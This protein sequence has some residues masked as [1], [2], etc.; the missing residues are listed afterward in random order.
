M[1]IEDARLLCAIR[2]RYFWGNFVKPGVVGGLSSAEYFALPAI[3]KSGLDLFERS[4]LHYWSENLD[5]MHD[6]SEGT[7]ATS[8]GSAIHCAILEP[9]RFAEEYRA[10]PVPEDFPG[11]L[12]SA[13][14]Y[15]SAA[16]SLDLPVT[17]TK[18]VLKQRI[19]E[20]GSTHRFFD[21]IENEFSAFRLLSAADLHAIGR[22]AAGVRHSE[23]ARILFGL[24]R[25]ELTFV[26]QDPETNVWC[27]CRVDRITDDLDILTDI[28]STRDASPSGFARSSAQYNYHRQ[29]AWYLDGVF[30]ATGTRPS[31]FAFAAYE[32]KAPFASAFYYADLEMLEIGRRENREL[33][34]RYAECLG[35]GKWPGYPQELRPLSLPAWRARREQSPTES[36]ESPAEMENY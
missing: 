1:T 29:A 32:T 28:K 33:L 4:P 19:K 13:D 23:A 6:E 8:L 12:V 24:G 34:R 20:A 22:I 35:S 10:K 18:E 14:D 15:K 27:K 2:H 16:R 26:W 11:C 25:S 31:V 17:G 3:N 7:A 9:E 36:A 21:E 30:H 5:P